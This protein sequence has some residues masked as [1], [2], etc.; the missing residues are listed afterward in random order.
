M[1]TTRAQA[2]CPTTRARKAKGKGPSARNAKVTKKKSSAIQKKDKKKPTRS[3]KRRTKDI[4]VVADP[5]PVQD[6]DPTE[7][8]VEDPAPQSD[9]P[10]Q[11]QTEAP[12]PQSAAATNAEVQSLNDR[13]AQQTEES[14]VDLKVPVETQPR[15]TKEVKDTEFRETVGKFYEDV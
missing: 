15:R 9:A 6:S 11:D 4:A 3:S 5:A 13:I 10:T 8:S 12:A 14:D 7:D 1:A 2:A